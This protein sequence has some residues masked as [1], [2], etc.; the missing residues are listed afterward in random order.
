[1]KLST[2]NTALMLLV[3]FPV[4]GIYHSLVCCELLE[5]IDEILVRR[6]RYCKDNDISMFACL[7]DRHVVTN[8]LESCPLGF[9]RI[10][11]ADD[12]CVIGIH[13][14]SCE[15]STK[16]SCSDNCNL[17]GILLVFMVLEVYY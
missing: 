17:L 14:A 9:L 3:W 12:H 13:D 10:A 6:S 1:M 11:G 4:A 5:D 8:D 7:G 16:L 2:P 15:G